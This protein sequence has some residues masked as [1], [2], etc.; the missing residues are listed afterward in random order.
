MYVGGLALS[1][2]KDVLI[3]S[4]R[5]WP[6]GHLWAPAHKT[7]LGAISWRQAAAGGAVCLVLNN[8]DSNQNFEN[9]DLVIIVIFSL[10]WDQVIITHFVDNKDNNES[11]PHI[12]SLFTL[13]QCCLDWLL[14]SLG[15]THKTIHHITAADTTCL[16]LDIEPVLIYAEGNFT[17]VWYL[18]RYV[19]DETL[20]MT[21][22]VVDREWIFFQKIWL[23]G[24]KI[25][26]CWRA[27]Y[28]F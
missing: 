9:Y 16:L 23:W 12:L 14:M 3:F 17:M 6:L 24:Y 22:L 26:F 4:Y 11:F 8:Q 2:A 13:S 18:L 10:W 1:T 25:L 5:C 21:R 19:F 28:D 7:S 20:T 15:K 27:N